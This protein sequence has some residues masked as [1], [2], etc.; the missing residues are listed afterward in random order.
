[1]K[2]REIRATR[3]R[4]TFDLSRLLLNEFEAVCA[5]NNTKRNLVLLKMIQAYVEAD[6]DIQKA[7]KRRYAVIKDGE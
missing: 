1:M 4:Y 6:K 3:C 5:L 2:S 7:L